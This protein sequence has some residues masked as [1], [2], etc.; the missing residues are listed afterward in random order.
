MGGQTGKPITE[1]LK[2]DVVID[3]IDTV[4]TAQ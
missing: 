3:L 4:N 2:E 1:K